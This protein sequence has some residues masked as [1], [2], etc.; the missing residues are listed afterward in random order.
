MTLKSYFLSFFFFAF[1]GLLKAQPGA[2]IQFIENK[3]QWDSRVKFRTDAG[4]VS[5][6][7]RNTGY[8]I[9]QQNS[10]DFKTI[11]EYTH[12]HFSDDGV[13]SRN[14]KVLRSHAF[15]VDFIGASKIYKIT[16]GK[17]ID[18]Y[19]NYFYGNDPAKWAANCKIFQS[20]AVKNIYPNIDL[21]YY[22]RNGQLKYDIIV[23]PG[24]DIKK[25][26]LKYD[27]VNNLTV[28][29][30]QLKI[31]LSTG[32]IKEDEPYTYGYDGAER[33][34]VTCRYVL[35]DKIVRFEAGN[36]DKSSIL[37]I[38]PTLIFSGLSGSTTD[39]WGYTAT[40]GPDGSMFGGGTAFAAGFPVSPGAFQTTWGGGT[41]L[42][43]SDITIIKLN[44]DGTKKLYATY[45]G[46]TGNDQ[47]NSFIADNFGNLVILGRS[48]SVDYPVTG[49]NGQIGSSGGYDI[50]VTKLNASG[51]SLIGSKKIGGTGDDGVNI[52]AT[53]TGINSL[54]QNFGDDGRSEVI[55]DNTGNIYI[56]S[57]TQSINFPVTGGVFQP[58]K[59]A[60]QD[61]LLLKLPA[62]VSGLSFATYLGGSGD[63]AA[64]SIA[65]APDGDIYVAGGTTSTDFPGNK[66]G[67]IG[68]VSSGNIDGFAA[69]IS[70]NGTVVIR[71]TYIGTAGIDQVM[72]IQFDKNGFPYIMGQTTGVWPVINAVYSNPGA[73]QFIAKLQPDLSAFVY[74]TVFGS[75]AVRP[76]ISPV[77]FFVDRSENVYVTGW[78]GFFGTNNSYSSSGTAGMPVT[79]NAFKPSTDGKDFYLFALKK[80]A[81]GIL[82]GSFF[83][84]VNTVSG[85]ADHTEGG[86]SRFDRNGVLYLGI[87]G[88]CR[89]LDNNAIY[90]T[91]NGSQNGASN[92]CN[93]AMLK[94]AFNFADVA[95]GIQSSIGG[96]Q[97]D[98]AGCVPLVVNFSDTVL[99]GKTYE[100]NF[101]DGPAVVSTTSSTISH[102]YNTKG[103]YKVMLVAID[104][105]TANKRDTSYLTIKAGDLQ[106]ALSFNPVKLTP[107]DS[108]RYRFTN[109]SVA[110]IARPFTN[111]SFTWDFGDSSGKITS[112][113]N[114]VQHNYTAPGVYDVRLI[115]TDTSYCNYS[116][117]VI[118]QIRVSALVK[119]QFQSAPVGCASRS[120]VF[121]NTSLGGQ[122]FLWNFGDSA[123]SGEVDPTHLFNLPGVYK[124]TLIAIDSS[125]CNFSDTLYFNINI[126]PVPAKP[127]ISIFG[128]AMQSSASA[129]NQWF[130]NGTA[131]QGATGTT[132]TPLQSGLYTV[133]SAINGCSGE[134]SDPFNYIFTAIN[135]PELNKR[136]VM[137]PNPV[138]D[139]IFIQYRGNDNSIFSLEVLNIE[140]ARL[141]NGSFSKSTVLNMKNYHTGIY[142]IRI[143]N[144]KSKEQI[145]RQ[146]LKK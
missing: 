117:T 55:M 84:E 130:L 62:D 16:G 118:K 88:N 76:N 99:S 123:V 6:F 35:K 68:T 91:T 11:T 140:G 83:G 60:Q 138:T 54:Q 17:P 86:T 95:A 22:S 133:Q 61:G 30:N 5:F 10:E 119:A 101:G 113:L 74:S 93:L 59:A 112:G 25:I 116:D 132:Y 20:I 8:T 4:P 37:V 18:T 104:S 80:N 94:V 63:D 56:S 39:N 114:N 2:G 108:F 115:L 121:T 67:T 134:L 19:N 143:E 14:K 3:G 66:T 128:S 40:Y 98:T 29:N 103:I 78:G 1:Y 46:G 42:L 53:R 136:I 24:G 127:V 107:C 71:S 79:P 23:R 69:Q 43:K 141:F 75:S 110:P 70:N 21:Q 102:I 28:E 26:A 31:G 36:Y 52:S 82:F 49:S 100:W 87:C 72:G 32:E 106:A 33:K 92:G 12:G 131:I 81:S 7:V 77:A 120:V 105:S 48:N 27:G 122:R 85:G 41:E 9:L 50:I 124:V 58:A 13:S 145:R 64:Y 137:A 126:F 109:L 142:I 73:K 45:I 135:S 47:P 144:K 34:T 146:I 38:D 96:V 51:T 65:L 15:N 97:G 111:T 139:N 89:Q 57:C 90:P 125:S 129:G 44:P